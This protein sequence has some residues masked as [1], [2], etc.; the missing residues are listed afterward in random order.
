[1]GESPRE[2]EK[3]LHAMPAR[4]PVVPTHTRLCLEDAPTVFGNSPGIGTG[5]PTRT[6]WVGFEGEMASML[7]VLEPALT[8]KMA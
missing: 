3:L 6:S 1:M 4:A 7:K 8:A 5:L 2:A